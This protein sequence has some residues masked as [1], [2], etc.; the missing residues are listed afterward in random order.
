MKIFNNKKDILSS[1]RIALCCLFCALSVS[2]V[3]DNISLDNPD[4]GSG[5]LKGDVLAF[6]M[7]LDKSLT[8]RDGATSILNTSIEGK[9]D[10]IDMQDKFRIFFFSVD[11]D[12]L[13]GA[14]DRIVGSV[15]NRPN[16]S[17]KD[18]W[19]IRIPMTMIVDRTGAEYDINKIK[20]YLKKYPFKIA[21]LANWPNGGEK[22]KPGEY[23]DSEGNLGNGFNPSST[24]KGEPLWGWD[25][26]ILNGSASDIK[27]LN[28][29]HNLYADTYYSNT[30]SS[31]GR[32]S[33]YEVYSK[34][35]KEGKNEDDETV[36]KVG[37]PTDW[38][39][40][41]SISEGWKYKD[42]AP[43]GEF[44]TKET[45]NQWIR[46]NWD[47]DVDRN[48]NKEIYRHYQ[49]MWYLW[50]FNAI[51]KIGCADNKQS[52]AFSQYSNNF[53][54]NDGKNLDGSA[55]VN[56]WGYKFWLRNGISI[57]KWITGID[58]NTGSESQNLKAAQAFTLPVNLT[59]ELELS[60][61][62]D[63]SNSAFLEFV[64]PSTNKAQFVKV[65][66]NYG[67]K[68]P[69]LENRGKNS[70]NN[71]AIVSDANN[72]LGYFK[73]LARTSG[74]LRIKWGSADNT[75]ATLVVQKGG[76]Q[77]KKY[78]VA[79]NNQGN[80]FDI[81]GTDNST[82]SLSYRD[83]SV[84]EDSQP[85][86]IW[87]DTG[88]VVIYAIEYIRG[89]YLYDS[90]RE[91]IYP[92]EDQG[93]PMYGVQQF[94]A[95]PDW[96]YGT[97]YNLPINVSLIRSLAKV[98]VHIPTSF[99][100]PRH[101]YM[102]C[103]NRTAF[104]EPM[105]VETNTSELWDENKHLDDSDGIRNCEWFNIFEYGPSFNKKGTGIDKE[106]R[107]NEHK[108]KNELTD[109]INWLA[110]SHGS[111]KNTKWNVSRDYDSENGMW[112]QTTANGYSFDGVTVD[113]YAGSSLK[114]V[115]GRSDKYPHLFNPHMNRSDF[116]HFIYTGEN[117][118]YYR[119]VL[120]VPDKNIDDPNYPGIF[121][122]TPKVPHIEY[123]FD[124][125]KGEASA[126][127]AE[128][129]N[130]EFNLDDNDCYRIYFT[131]YGFDSNFKDTPDNTNI[132][133]KALG[134]YDDYEK[135]RDNL[136][137][138]W[139]IMRSHIYEFFVSGSGPETPQISVK[140]TDWSHEKVIIE[141]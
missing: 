78:T 13:F 44:D 27:N 141:W 121:Y 74:T 139:P 106:V 87:C 57:F 61:V 80:W 112:K 107:E 35:Y 20:A 109:Y 16:S 32:P 37:E 73:F 9:D 138:H 84:G 134:A 25:N 4:D 128:Y 102:R 49:H 110:W 104:C 39:K 127:D 86:Y 60:S 111:W 72:S 23:D 69:P 15:E 54:W 108:G 101:M 62:G 89:K 51:Y 129:S 85:I 3:D 31:S 119:Y 65:G 103:M 63:G 38:V 53:G 34:F 130:T 45:A 29:L 28:D 120:Y 40:M 41:R 1:L 59:S 126:A 14:N 67:V 56:R 18:Y 55:T 94:N 24:L 5:Q 75:A 82:G 95:I 43:L 21:V 48:N 113:A 114:D 68:L 117:N 91:G 105:D 118:G 8:T 47:P 100:K 7:E 70:T 122:C 11:G 46:Y 98:I 19:Y 88:N 96:E 81:N 123:R 76:T 33:R 36:L 42:A 133:D 64:P 116:C 92:N 12:F 66:N 99:G 97:T 137:Y 125:P 83:I 79:E 30:E 71:N 2:C 26:S 140:V 52:T 124:P 93:I 115:K 136:A 77:D 58:Y 22:I 50:N 90:D 17:E 131:N 6:T 132:R 10:W 135:S